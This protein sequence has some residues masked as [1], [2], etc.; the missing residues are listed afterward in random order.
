MEQVFDVSELDAHEKNGRLRSFKIRMCNGEEVHLASE[1]KD[2]LIDWLSK[3]QGVRQ[4]LDEH[5]RHRGLL[6]FF[7]R[8]TATFRPVARF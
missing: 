4:Q 1:N 8:S 6:L 5:V 2:D 7:Q 3:L